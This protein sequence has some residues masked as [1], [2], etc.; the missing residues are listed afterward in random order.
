VL[1]SFDGQLSGF[2][3]VN[4]LPIFLPATAFIPGP[5]RSNS[6]K[7]NRP[8]DSDS[9]VAEGNLVGLGKSKETMLVELHASCL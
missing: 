1:C 7:S 9:G 3:Q 5:D 4:S 2:Q 8:G 6:G